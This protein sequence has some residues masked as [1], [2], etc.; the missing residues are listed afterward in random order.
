MGGDSNLVLLREIKIG[1]NCFIGC[2][3]YHPL[4]GTSAGGRM[5]SLVPVLWLLEEI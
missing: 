1:K 2:N 3:M 4:K 5:L